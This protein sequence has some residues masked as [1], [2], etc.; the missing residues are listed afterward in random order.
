MKLHTLHRMIF[1]GLL[2]S[3]ATGCTK[4]LRELN[5]DPTGATGENFNPNY[6]LSTAE[7]RYT[8]SSDFGIECYAVQMG[9]LSTMVQHFATA[10]T[11]G[12]NGDKYFVDPVDASQYFTVA[13]NEQVKFV[14]DGLQLAKDKPQYA[15]LY[16]VLRI[17]KVII[18]H[19][20]TDLYG[21]VPYAKA[22]QGYYQQIL[23]PAYDTQ[24][25]IYNDML[26]ELREAAAA[27]DPAKDLPT[28]DFVYNGNIAS[29]KKLAYSMMLRLGM[30]L[31]KVN[32]GAA[33]AW[34]EEAIAGGVFSSNTD[35]AVILH[36]ASGARP[37]V[38]RI[39]NNFKERGEV[40]AGVKWSKT[41]IDFLKSQNDPRLPILSEV[42]LPGGT[43]TIETHGSV[44]NNDP[45]VQQGMPNGYDLADPRP[46]TSEPDYPGAQGTNV[47]GKYSRPRNSILFK[48]GA[49]TFII[50]YAEVELMQAE[51]KKLGFTLSGT[52][53]Q[54]YNAGVRAAME[55]LKQF[56]ATAVIAPTAID[57]Y[58][59]AHPYN[60]TEGLKMIGEQF[61]VATILNDYESF[62][63][64]R[65]TGFPALRP[66]NHPNGNTGGV[67]PRRMLY[68][69]SEAATNGLNYEQALSRMGGVNSM[70]TRVW[71]DRP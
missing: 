39:S 36:D 16:Q 49:P 12:W 23:T 2:I 50:S 43:G 57:A 26:K 14:V 18:F 1:L 19:R 52:V 58:L 42:P 37:T 55:T 22:G 45:L 9:Y 64:W 51:A 13:Y 20:L 35:N 71:W 29:W 54:H 41:F 67:L 7:L 53:A 15:N 60:D 6:L 34:A 33:K 17:W 31:T 63:N 28:G 4:K 40:V 5:I 32:A 48:L 25:A 24:E 59:L 56:D 3:I 66:I 10:T 8:G 30:R 46:I 62:A 38:N 61:W 68:P 65:R 70:L 11:P 27:L 69:Q 21:D 47:I 44:G